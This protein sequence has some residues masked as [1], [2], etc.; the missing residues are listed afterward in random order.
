MTVNSVTGL[1]IYF[2]KGFHKNVAKLFK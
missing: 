2:D 1:K